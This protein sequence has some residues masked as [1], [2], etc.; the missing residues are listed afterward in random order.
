MNELF[1]AVSGDVLDL[2]FPRSCLG[3]GDALEDGEPCRFFC[4]LCWRRFE[5][6]RFPCCEKCGYPFYGEM[7]SGR[8]CPNCVA[9]NPSFDKG[10]AAFLL[11]G[12]GQVFV[13][14]LKYRGITG[15]LNDLSVLLDQVSHFKDFLR[16]A[17]LVSVPLH[18]RRRRRRGYNQ[19]ELIARA[20]ASIID[21]AEFADPLFRTRSTP[22]QTDL[23]RERRMKNVKN[24]FAPKPEAV[25]QENRRYVVIDDVIT[26]GSTLEACSLALRE[27]GVSCVDVA[28]LAHG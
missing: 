3:C 18:K 10:R 5:W 27:A 21:G 26:T 8:E 15:V 11:S 28:V 17:V 7:L 23:P 9:L 14:A 13:H 20:L 12:M 4:S 1:R 6:V 2:F 24:A 16:D 22:T 19:A 25:M